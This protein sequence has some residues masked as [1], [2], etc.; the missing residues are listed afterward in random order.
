[1]NNYFKEIVT[2]EQYPTKQAQVQYVAKTASGKV[3]FVDDSERN[4]ENCK[5]LGVLSFYFARNPDPKDAEKAWY[6]LLNL[7]DSWIR[8]KNII[9]SFYSAQLTQHVLVNKDFSA[10]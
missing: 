9:N 4:I 2:R 1:M 5:G 10:F 8:V 3:L 6:K 7:I